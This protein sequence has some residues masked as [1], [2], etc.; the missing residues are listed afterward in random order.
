MEKLDSLSK[1]LLATGAINYMA[2]QIDGV[3]QQTKMLK[4]AYKAKPDLG[5]F[6]GIHGEGIKAKDE[7]LA[8][9]VQ[10]LASIME[11][12]GNLINGHDCLCPIDQYAT[13][14][15]FMI[16]VQGKDDV[17]YDGEDDNN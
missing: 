14:A 13:T 5:D 9:V 1:I 2:S 10:R 8:E 6:D 3:S 15:P 11:D 7:L 4:M 16:V 17:D 12:M